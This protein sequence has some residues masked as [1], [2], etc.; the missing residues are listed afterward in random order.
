MFNK[1][2]PRIFFICLPNSTTFWEIDILAKDHA[3]TM[4]LKFRPAILLI[5]AINNYQKYHV[6]GELLVF[7]SLELGDAL[8]P[9]EA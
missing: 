6:G 9:V 8:P 1:I 2:G 3:P 4:L 7:L 5:S